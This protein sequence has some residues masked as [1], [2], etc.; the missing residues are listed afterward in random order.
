MEPV[1]VEPGEP[2]DVWV[3]DSEPEPEESEPDGSNSSVVYSSSSSSAG[4][5]L[6]SDPSGAFSGSGSESGESLSG[7]S[8]RSSMAPSNVSE[9]SDLTVMSDGSGSGLDPGLPPSGGGSV[10]L[11]LGG[12]KLP[13]LRLDFMDG[14]SEVEHSLRYVGATDQLGCYCSLHPGCSRAKVCHPG[15]KRGQ[16]TPAGALGAW[17]LLGYLFDSA[18]SHMGFRSRFVDKQSRDDARKLLASYG[19]RAVLILDKEHS[20]VEPGVVA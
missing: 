1:A 2:V 11:G 5:D 6:E 17:A 19:E 14:V 10:G 20:K 7:A 18:E 8:S 12:I 15:R 13:T 16:G 4:S 3:A 9:L